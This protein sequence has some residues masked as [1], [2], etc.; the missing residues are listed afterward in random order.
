MKRP[1]ICYLCGLPLL[2]DVSADHIPPKQFY[3][4][5]VR[6]AHAP[7]L[8]TLAAH[9][10]CNKSFQLDEDYFTNSLVPL[11]DSYSG[12]SV[13]LDKA[14]D[15][16]KGKDVRL[17]FG[18]LKEFDKK[19]SGLVLPPGVIAKRYDG[20]RVRRVIWKIVRGLYFRERS[21]V[22]SESSRRRIRLYDPGQKPGDEFFLVPSEIELG[23]YPGVFAARRRFVDDP[24]NRGGIYC[25]LFWDKIVAT[26]VF[27]THEENANSTNLTAPS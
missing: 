16:Q 12:P 25:L 14:E 27:E 3:G 6:K 11:A 24:K 5:E 26:V 13:L 2:D 21:I 1:D 9:G 17:H 10:K 15:H 4:K 20:T 8:V 23:S 7:N 19:P 22:L 18:I